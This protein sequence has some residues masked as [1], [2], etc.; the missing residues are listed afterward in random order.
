MYFRRKTSL[1]IERTMDRNS[2]HIPRIETDLAIANATVE[3]IQY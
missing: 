1:H 2:I 3:E